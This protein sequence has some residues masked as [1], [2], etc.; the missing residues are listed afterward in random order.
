[1]KRAKGIPKDGESRRQAE[2]RLAGKERETGLS[3]AE[4]DALRMVHE[5]QVHQI[6]LELQN[7][8]LSQARAEL[9]RQLD[10]YS[11]LYNFA[12]VG[13]FT[14]DGDGTIQEANLTG[15]KLLEMERSRLAGSRLISF[16][17]DESLRIF[18]RWLKEI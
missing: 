14:L 1:V 17:S 7:E 12:P 11:D 16:L 4:Q 5:L 13:Y 9:E 15:A 3:T 6:E 8:E 10:K 18:D 2:E